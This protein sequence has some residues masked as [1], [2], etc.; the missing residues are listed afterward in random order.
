MPNSC[1]KGH[2]KLPSPAELDLTRSHCIS[3]KTLDTILYL[4]VTV[5]SS[6]NRVNIT[7]TG[8]LGGNQ[9]AKF[10]ASNGF[11]QQAVVP[12]PS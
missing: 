7:F 5:F 1:W 8:V 9:H 10:L 12:I 2:G 3:C 4:P 11:F 6:L